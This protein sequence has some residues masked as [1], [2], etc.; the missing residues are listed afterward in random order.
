MLF[1]SENLID[2]EQ[3][4]DSFA[5]TLVSDPRLARGIYEQRSLN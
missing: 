3:R 1:N 4:R 2:A 5:R